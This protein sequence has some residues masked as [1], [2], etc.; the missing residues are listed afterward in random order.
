MAG[1]KLNKVYE[2]VQ[3]LANKDQSG[4]YI[5]PEEFNSNF[6]RA[7]LYL[8]KKLTG[9]P[10][11]YSP[12]APFPS[13]AWQLTARIQDDLSIFIKEITLSI[14]DNG[15]ADKPDDY[16][17]HDALWRNYSDNGVLKKAPVQVIDNDKW[18]RR[19]SH[20]INFPTERFPILRYTTGGDFEFAPSNLS[21]VTMSYLTIPDQDTVW[22]FTEV[23][24]EPVFDPVNSIDTGWN[25]ENLDQLADILL[26][27][28]GINIGDERVIQYAEAQQQKG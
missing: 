15:L 28:F 27:Y 8:F 25:E 2:F 21:F 23:N 3:Y 24:D 10:E 22:A 5:T 9:L 26:S 18:A 1:E 16:L 17:R 7:S 19:F 11:S 12:G 14:D 4:G 13:I 6:Q 20:S